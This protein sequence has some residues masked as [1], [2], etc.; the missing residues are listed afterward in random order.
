MLV[1]ICRRSG[2]A[3]L[4]LPQ[5]YESMEIV[6]VHFVTI[7]LEHALMQLTCQVQLR[8]FSWSFSLGINF[9]KRNILALLLCILMVFFSVFCVRF[10]HDG[11]VAI[12]VL[13]GPIV[14]AMLSCLEVTWNTEIDQGS[15][16]NRFFCK[17]FD[18]GCSTVEPQELEVSKHLLPASHEDA[19]LACAS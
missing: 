18:E 5:Q 9:H 15:P 7:N 2:Y 3:R 8:L 1:K 6:K 11:R 14:L 12:I 19:P 10:I 4:I 17:S 13:A 16:W